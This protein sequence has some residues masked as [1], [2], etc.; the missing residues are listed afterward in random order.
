MLIMGGA[1]LAAVAILQ[2]YIIN[3]YNVHSDSALE[4]FVFSRYVVTGG[5]IVA[6]GSTYHFIGV[7]YT[8]TIMG[9]I[10]TVMRLGLNYFIYLGR[11]C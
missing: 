11:G 10:S 2:M 5:I 3:S 4:F 1:I 8:L 7:H 6:G 9:S